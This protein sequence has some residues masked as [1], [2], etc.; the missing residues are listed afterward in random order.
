MKSN[1]IVCQD[2]KS[3]EIFL[4][5]EYILNTEEKFQ[6]R[7]CF[8]CRLL[9][10]YPQPSI[11]TLMRYYASDKYFAYR[12]S[13]KGGFYKAIREYIILNYCKTNIVAKL[14]SFFVHNSFSMP[15]HIKN[16]K[17]LDIGCGVGDILLLLKKIGFKVFGLEIDKKAVAIARE[18]GLDVKFGTFEAAGEYDDNYFDSIRLYH[19]IEH[20]NDPAECLRIARRKLKIGG[21]LIMTTPN[22]RCLSR[23][24]FGRYWSSLD[25]PRHLFIFNP[26]SISF[27][28]GQEGFDV[29]SIEYNTS[30]GF[31]NS[32]HLVIFEV[33]KRR[34]RF[35]DTFIGNVLFY[36]L[37]MVLMVF[38]MSD[39]FTIR[40]VKTSELIEKRK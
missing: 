25:S 23:F 4:S 27:L 31:L 8:S 29:E 15:S 10:V 40:A 28:A 24:V 20:L 6:I 19:V 14:L 1:C 2:V 3:K 30:V 11:K 13:G 5:K 9:F 7:E 22:S 21:E 18:K 17:V 33:L 35:L 34:I 26:T 36:P 12:E 39:S 32:L 37:E 38:H 16:G